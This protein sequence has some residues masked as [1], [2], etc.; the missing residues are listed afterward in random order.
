MTVAQDID[1]AYQRAIAAGVSLGRPKG[2][3]APA[4]SGFVREYDGGT[5][6]WDPS[7]SAAHEVH[8]GILTEYL[9]LGGPSGT[10]Q[11][12]QLLGFP[13]TDETSRY[14]GR[15]ISSRF[16]F[17]AIYWVRG[18][19]AVAVTDDWWTA[20]PLGEQGPLSLPV[21]A[22]VRVWDA[23][24]QLFET[25]CM[26]RRNG[27]ISLCEALDW[28]RLARPRLT[29]PSGAITRLFS[30]GNAA[31]SP[32]VSPLTAIGRSRGSQPAPAIVELWG[33]RLGL[34][35]VGGATVT[36]LRMSVRS[37][38]TN[39]G[40][41][42]E[43]D[44]TPTAPLRD[45]QLYDLVAW[46]LGNG[47]EV[48]VSPHC[49]Y[50]CANWT[51][52]GFLH[53]TDLHMSGWNDELQLDA[54]GIGARDFVNFNDGLRETI[55][56]ANALHAAGR[57]DVA[58]ATG[59]LVD[60][61]FDH[62][63]DRTGGGNFERLVEILRGTSASPRQ[64][65]AGQPDPVDTEPL[66]IPIFMV[67]GNHDYRPNPYHLLFD[68][69]VSV[70]SVGI[71]GPEVPNFEGFN[72][73]KDEARQ[74]TDH[75]V[76]RRTGSMP[77]R[78][79]GRNLEVSSADAGQMVAA[80]VPTWLLNRMIRMTAGGSY[81]VA[82]GPHRIVMIDTGHDKGIINTVG[83]VTWAKFVDASEDE[84]SFLGGSPNQEGVTQLHIG[85]VRQAL[86][87]AGNRGVVMVGMHGPPINP[88]GNEFAHYFRET[89]HPTADRRETTAFVAR[90]YPSVAR[91]AV[92]DTSDPDWA[93]DFTPWFKIGDPDN[94]LD[95]GVS[96]GPV[97]AFLATVAGV[98]LS[99]PADL[100]MC[101]HGHR[102]VDYR[103]SAD[104]R[105]GELRFH[106]DFYFDQ[107]SRYYASRKVDFP[108]PVQIAVLPGAPLRA[109]P[110][111]IRDQR[112]LPPGAPP[113]EY[114]TLDVP[115]HPD[116]LAS[117]PNPAQWWRLKRPFV[118][119]T[120]AVGPLEN[121]Q[122]TMPQE[123]T[124][125]GFRFGTVDGPAVVA[126]ESITLKAARAAK[127]FRPTRIRPVSPGV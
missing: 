21:A 83:A 16:E 61:A 8:G 73:T 66:E 17:G 19:G 47:R 118:V 48:V 126:L 7:R 111:H 62:G 33:E 108:N 82:L 96:K 98:G 51:R 102:R 42:L 92:N 55:L 90:R 64:N 25:G 123:P 100:V 107:P 112:G 99:R 15:S 119:Q 127:Y 110:Q 30:A 24:I 116:P 74:I 36:P 122:R 77:V 70:G 29:T 43:L 101:G 117:T 9:R 86:I 28:P 79:P 31:A 121:T 35:P 3:L 18:A 69:M 76:A 89:E 78:L 26:V 23:E 10:I 11:G 6:Y 75:V 44:A 103:V 120:G 56:A 93:R 104:P 67:P 12:R 45:R 32:L 53:L 80:E 115:P 14:G 50:A 109:R 105:T 40:T 52:F 87:D 58:F 72:L 106:L 59:D 113:V 65:P 27:A 1:A 125:R 5:I 39:V 85:A 114:D 54:Y 60:F 124:F 37:A 84:R 13:I 49:V 20:Y 22:P 71:Y 91:G 95:S 81:T 57:L 4:A 88:G 63:D 41:F 34:R 46:N 94:W 38:T 68:A 2:G 97:S